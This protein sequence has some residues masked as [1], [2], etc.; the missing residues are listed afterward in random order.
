MKL[1]IMHSC[2]IQIGTYRVSIY[3]NIHDFFDSNY[4]LRTIVIDNIVID[5]YYRLQKRTTIT[6]IVQY[7]LITVSSV[8]LVP[9]NLWSV[10]FTFL[11]AMIGYVSL[12]KI[13]RSK[14]VGNH[15]SGF[16]Q[17]HFLIQI[18]FNARFGSTES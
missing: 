9:D 15:R 5:N 3:Y 18:Y 11:V 6:S 17:H 8:I 2:C 13:G 14:L 10:L 1:Q 4:R 12:I 16:F 7:L